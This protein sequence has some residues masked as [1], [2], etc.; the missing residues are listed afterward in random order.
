MTVPPPNDLVSFASTFY[1]DDQVNNAVDT[2][3]LVRGL[4]L[5]DFAKMTER[6]FVRLFE[7][8][9]QNGTGFLDGLN[10]MRTMR[11]L[12][13]RLADQR[14]DFLP[15]QSVY[16]HSEL[17]SSASPASVIHRI[18]VKRDGSLFPLCG[19]LAD[20]MRKSPPLE[21][22]QASRKRVCRSCGA[23]NLQEAWYRL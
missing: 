10:N 7:S 3:L 22:G 20:K 23:F 18:L 19:R 5:S 15:N 12:M 14:I 9:S 16:S 4:E 11:G 8:D 17:R 13:Q 21:F 2:F 1:S 6:E